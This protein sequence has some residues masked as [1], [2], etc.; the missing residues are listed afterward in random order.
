MSTPFVLDGKALAKEIE[1]DLTTRVA[2]LVEKTGS[3]PTLATILVGDDPASVTYVRMKGNA[4]RR[5]GITPLKIEMPQETTTEELLAQ[6]DALNADDNVCGILLQH[7]VPSQIDEQACFN[8]I[9]PDKD[10][11]GVNITTFGAM[12]MKLPSYFS[13]TPFSI[14]SILKRYNIEISGKDVVVVGRSPILGKPVAMML[15]N[16]NATVTICHTKTRDLPEKVR[17]ADIVVAAVGR[18]KFIQADWIKE[19]AV[20]VDA[21]Y[22]EGNV[23]DIDLEN[24][25]PKSSAYTPVPG[26]VGPVTIA[27]LIEQTVQSAERK[28]GIS[29]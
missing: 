24:A 2:A 22:N 11:D 12:T 28:A 25:A 13:A 20:L 15:L 6:I 4:C 26:G 17:R 14:L 10:V 7:P 23:G 1:A 8:R 21:G 18:P 5:V 27:K 3:A 29:K 19:G 16:E 9:A